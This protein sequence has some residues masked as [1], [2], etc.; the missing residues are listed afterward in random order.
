MR[1]DHEQLLNAADT[2]YRTRYGREVSPVV[3]DRYLAVLVEVLC[4][5]INEQ[6]TR[7]QIEEV[8]E[9]E[10]AHKLAV[11]LGLIRERVFNGEF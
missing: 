1:L 2:I 11:E 7:A 8:R 9:Q 4:G 3:R 10:A 6:H 5:Y